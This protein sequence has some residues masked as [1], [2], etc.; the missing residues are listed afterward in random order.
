MTIFVLFAHWRVLGVLWGDHNKASNTTINISESITAATNISSIGVFI[1]V[2][3]L[4]MLLA[5]IVQ[6]ASQTVLLLL[7]VTM[8]FMVVA[9]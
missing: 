4:L 5:G 6:S 9:F 3:M 7:C 8:A 2:V 1:S